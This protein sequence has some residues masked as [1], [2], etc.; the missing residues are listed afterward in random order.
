MIL[1][2]LLLLEFSNLASSQCTPVTTPPNQ[3]TVV[4]PDNGTVTSL[5]FVVEFPGGDDE[6][7]AQPA[8]NSDLLLVG[9]SVLTSNN[10]TY[11]TFNFFSPPNSGDVFE[12]FFDNTTNSIFFNQSVFITFEAPTTTVIATTSTPTPTTPTPTP[13]PHST[14]SPRCGV[15]SGSNLPANRILFPEQCPAPAPPPPA[16]PAPQPW[17]HGHYSPVA[18]TSRPNLVS[19]VKS[20]SNTNSG[21][22]SNTNSGGKNLFPGQVHGSPPTTTTNQHASLV[23]SSSKAATTTTTTTTKAPTKKQTTTT[24]TTT[25]PT[26]GKHAPI[27]TPTTT[28][29]RKLFP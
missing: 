6:V 7:Q 5:V 14:T 11:F 10:N 28:P 3:Q 15:P 17:V 18:T 23:K 27:T 2:L 26:I 4:Y 1:V 25:K 29:K 13:T 20:S 21:S 19:N 8:N 16:P 22:G 12:I 24:T 9:C